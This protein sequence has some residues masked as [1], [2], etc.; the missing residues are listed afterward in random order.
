M[1]T[2]DYDEV[3]ASLSENNFEN[4][5]SLIVDIETDQILGED[6]F[7]LN[8]LMKKM[9]KSMES[10]KYTTRTKRVLNPTNPIRL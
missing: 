4:I 6:A 10:K 8:Y 7:K 2:I 1:K 9:K 3:Y 5:E